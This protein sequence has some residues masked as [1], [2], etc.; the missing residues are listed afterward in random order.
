MVKVCLRC[1]EEFTP[2]DS[3]TI[4]C[5]RRCSKMGHSFTQEVK[6]KMSVTRKGRTHPQERKEKMR[7]AQLKR[8][9][10]GRHNTYT[11][12]K[13]KTTAYIYAK[14]R[15]YFIRRQDAAGSH[16]KEQWE[17]LKKLYGFI[18][19]SCKI[20][21]PIITLVHDHIIPLSKGGSDNIENIQPLCWSCNAKKQTKTI[22]YTFAR[23]SI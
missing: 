8:V 19:P 23:N 20:E 16:T 7:Q 17:N 11:D 12:G 9:A 6:D 2:K 3:R 18:C 5:S 22:R 21:E 13:S 14:N 4:H 10:E 1:K 15:R